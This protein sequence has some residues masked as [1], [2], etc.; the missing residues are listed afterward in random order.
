[1]AAY[2]LDDI[3]LPG[4]A[5]R[6]LLIDSAAADLSVE[7]PDEGEPYAEI[8]TNRGTVLCAVGSVARTADFSVI[9]SLGSAGWV[10]VI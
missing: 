7:T 2:L 9:K 4:L 8:E 6:T 1:M 5:V 10:D 3:N